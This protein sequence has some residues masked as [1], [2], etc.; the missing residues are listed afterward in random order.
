MRSIELEMGLS[1]NDDLVRVGG[2]TTASGHSS[3]GRREIRPF[4]ALREKC[5]LD[6]DT[7]LSLGTNSSSLRKS[8]FVFL[9]RGRMP[10]ISLLEKCAS[11][12]LLSNVVL[13]SPFT[14]S[15]WNS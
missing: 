5:A 14:H 8:R 2:D 15:S 6:V 7:F 11:T 3:S 9:E 13:G 1:S 4:H 12:R 10:V